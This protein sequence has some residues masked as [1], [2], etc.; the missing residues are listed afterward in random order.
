MNHREIPEHPPEQA[1]EEQPRSLLYRLLDHPVNARESILD[2]LFQVFF[3][4][5]LLATTVLEKVSGKKRS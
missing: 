3:K 1:L 2:K 5:L 4:V